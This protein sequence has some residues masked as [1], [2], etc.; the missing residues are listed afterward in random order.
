MSKNYS[1]LEAQ[2][3]FFNRATQAELWRRIVD[4]E[5]RGED[6]LIDFDPTIE[7]EANV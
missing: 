7:Q 6:S 2:D 5:A 3:A 1:V 4:V